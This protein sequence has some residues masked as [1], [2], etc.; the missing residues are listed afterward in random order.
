MS[1]WTAP[2]HL[3]KPSRPSFSDGSSVFITLSS[4]GI[5]H[6]FSLTKKEKVCWKK[7]SPL[8]H[9]IAEIL[10]NSKAH[11][12]QDHK[13][14]LALWEQSCFS[15]KLSGQASPGQGPSEGWC[16]EAKDFCLPCWPLPQWAPKGP[17]APAFHS[18]SSLIL[19]SF[20]EWAQPLPKL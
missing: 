11:R 18:Y 3:K 1:A 2:R 12:F 6:K 15:D 14:L 17:C 10:S 13:S 7:R 9:K 8:N 5:W 20:S 16:A 19:S 4:T